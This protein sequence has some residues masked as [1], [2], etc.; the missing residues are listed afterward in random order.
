MGSV[1]DGNI[2]WLSIVFGR[3]LPSCFHIICFEITDRSK[4]FSLSK[5]G[6]PG[7]RSEVQRA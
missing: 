1:S 3:L 2:Q 5:C 7:F 6:L 4:A